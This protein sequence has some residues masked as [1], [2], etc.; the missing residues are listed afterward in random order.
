M[1]DALLEEEKL[2]NE[3]QGRTQVYI[4]LSIILFHAYC[5]KRL[6]TGCFSG[7]FICRSSYVT[8]AKKGEM[9]PFTGYITNALIV[10]HTILGFSSIVGSA[11]LLHQQ[12]N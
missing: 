4:V 10:V 11:L 6:L 12:E 7:Q 5:C 2:P 1:L 8:T 9:L 3:Y